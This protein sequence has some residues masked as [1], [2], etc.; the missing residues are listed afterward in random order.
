V[1]GLGSP[2]RTPGGGLSSNCSL[3][4]MGA[5]SPLFYSIRRQ[6]GILGGLVLIIKMTY[7]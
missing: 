2:P 6:L 7:N 4:S 3:A 5:I 1:G